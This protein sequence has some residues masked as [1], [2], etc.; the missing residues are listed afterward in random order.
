MVLKLTSTKLNFVDFV[1]TF[2]FIMGGLHDIFLPHI[3]VLCI[4]ERLLQYC[5]KNKESTT[6]NF[7]GQKVYD[8]LVFFTKNVNRKRILSTIRKDS[9]D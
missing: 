2:V 9:T 7:L 6:S 4:I 3:F 1:T 5:T 8:T